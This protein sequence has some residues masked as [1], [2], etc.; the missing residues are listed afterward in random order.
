LKDGV[1]NTP[2]FFLP[3]YLLCPE[4]R[5]QIAFAQFHNDV[6]IVDTGVDIIAFND[7]RMVHY[8]E[9][10]YFTFEETGS[11][12][13]F[14]FLH[15]DTLDSDGSVTADVGAAEDLTET[16]LADFVVEVEHVVLNLFYDLQRV[17][18][19]VAH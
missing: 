5:V 3:K 2:N 4:L 12:F 7:V 10:G 14:D 9:Y 8:F 6:A 13:V 15:R 19:E 11:N 16:A 18:V 1:Y 17:W